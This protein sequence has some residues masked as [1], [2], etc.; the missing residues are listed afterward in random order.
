M[1]SHGIMAA[2][3]RHS[4]VI[5]GARRVQ[6]RE[7]PQAGV[8][9]RQFLCKSRAVARKLRG[10]APTP[11]L[12]ALKRAQEKAEH[13]R[14]GEDQPALGTRK[15]VGRGDARRQ[16]RLAPPKEIALR[17]LQSQCGCVTQKKLCAAG[18]NCAERAAKLVDCSGARYNARGCGSA[19]DSACA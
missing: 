8:R 9:G 10:I 6:I 12:E 2:L 14:Q 1:R 18:R 13:R 16:A 4:R 5:E 19:A 3:H 11:S 7:L 17:V 15:R